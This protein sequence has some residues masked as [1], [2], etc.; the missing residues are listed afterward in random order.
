[1]IL[2][3]EAASTTVPRSPH[4]MLCR[5]NLLHYG[6]LFL[7][8]PLVLLANFRP[9][10]F[11]LVTCILFPQIYLNA[12]TGT[13]PEPNSHYYRHFLLY[14]FLLVV[15]IFPFSFMFAASL[16]ISFD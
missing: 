16:T 9:I 1:M 15:F 11:L 6:S 7:V 14:R 3:F 10:F 13:R 2:I 5:F 8:Y 4:A 12:L